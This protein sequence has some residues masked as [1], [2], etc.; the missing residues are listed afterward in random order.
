MLKGSSISVTHGGLVLG[1]LKSFWKRRANSSRMVTPLPL[2]SA[3]YEDHCVT[4]KYK[5][6]HEHSIIQQVLTF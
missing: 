5:H 1:L 3:P 4:H 6:M 2:E